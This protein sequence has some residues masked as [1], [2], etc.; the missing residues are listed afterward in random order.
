MTCHFQ[1]LACLTACQTAF[2]CFYKILIFLY[3]GVFLPGWWRQRRG[4][5]NRSRNTVRKFTSRG[6]PTAGVQR[7]SHPPPDGIPSSR[8]SHSA[9][10]L[11]D[12]H[13]MSLATRFY[14]SP[15]VTF[16]VL[17]AHG[18]PGS[19][20]TRDASLPTTSLPA[21]SHPLLQ[22]TL[23]VLTPHSLH[24]SSQPHSKSSSLIPRPPRPLVFAPQLKSRP[25]VA[26]SWT[27]LPRAR[28]VQCSLCGEVTY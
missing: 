12:V 5:N 8:G 9:S 3:V 10:H 11:L 16:L 6:L 22:V 15:Q 26:S 18:I 17:A 20:G 24:P 7:A 23:L 27:I 13:T 21:S 25:S 1:L 28:L 4:R 2:S 19:R 14:P